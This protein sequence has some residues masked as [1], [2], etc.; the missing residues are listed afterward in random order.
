MKRLAVWIMAIAFV[1]SLAGTG[2]AL[3]SNTVTVSATV[4][5]SCAFNVAASALAF[6]VL[7]PALPG[8]PA[9]PAST[10]VDFWCTSGTAYTMTDDDGANEIVANGN[11]M[12]DGVNFIPYTF[13]YAPAAG[14][15]AGVGAPIT[16]T[17]SGSVAGADYLNAPPAAYGDTVVITVSP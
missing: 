11:R 4:I 3:D 9:V 15:G 10:T 5:G 13:S 2:L 6:G 17:I 12:T 16:L 14:F 1:V 8:P 7:D